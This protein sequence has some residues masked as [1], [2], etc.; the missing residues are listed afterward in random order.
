MF[1]HVPLLALPILRKNSVMLLI[2]ILIQCRYLMPWCYSPLITK[3]NSLNIEFREIKLQKRKP[4]KRS[5][6]SHSI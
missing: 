3:Q 4:R 6:L 2:Y 1:A 5:L